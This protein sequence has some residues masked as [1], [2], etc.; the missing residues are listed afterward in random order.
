MKVDGGNERRNSSVA[1]RIGGNEME[2]AH[3]SLVASGSQLALQLVN[4]RRSPRIPGETRERARIKVNSKKL[5]EKLY[6]KR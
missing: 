2:D 1:L 3:G 5:S 4:A 6:R